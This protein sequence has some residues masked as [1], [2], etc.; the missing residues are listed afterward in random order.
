TFI[1]CLPDELSISTGETVRVLA[2]YDD[3]WA[4]CVNGTGEQGMVPT[5]CLDSGN[6][7]VGSGD[8]R[9]SRRVSSL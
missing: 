6:G 5:E 7:R 3:G 2:R 9:A 1:P 8:W 4:M